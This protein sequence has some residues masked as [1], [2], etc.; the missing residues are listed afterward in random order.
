M[1]QNYGEPTSGSQTGSGSG[2][3]E[4]AKHEA[5]EVAGAAKA[6]AGHVV[7]TAKQE[8]AGVASEAKSQAKQVYAQTKQQLTEQ[9]ASQQQRVADGLRSIGDELDSLAQNSENPGIATDLVRQVSTRVSGASDWLSQRDPGSLVSEVKSFARRKPG[10]FIAGA[11]IAGVVAGR[12]T[13]AL[14]ESAKEEHDSAPASGATGT[15]VGGVPSAPSA[16]SP[17]PVNAPLDAPIGTP[18]SA[19]TGI[20]AA[21]S[22][23]SNAPVGAPLDEPIDVAPDAVEPTP[24]YDSS[25]GRT[26]DEPYTEG[27]GE[28]RDDR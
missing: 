28:R 1:S 15:T 21:P 5:G 26:A 24:L 18:G 8:A 7:E 17:A 11:L 6:E 4:T 27:I 3:A 23:P 20:P 14:T 19:A 22:A 12:L 2:T 25:V 10:V 13:R 16:P 9:A